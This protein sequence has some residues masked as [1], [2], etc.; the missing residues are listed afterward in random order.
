MESV[1][2]GERKGF[3]RRAES[4]S[5]DNGKAFNRQRTVDNG[6][7]ETPGWRAETALADCPLSM[8][9]D[10]LQAHSEG[11]GWGIK[12]RQETR[13]EIDYQ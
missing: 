9:H 11:D 8:F 1:S 5:I 7:I 4:P 12:S 13:Q 10:R 6:F 3:Q 2:N